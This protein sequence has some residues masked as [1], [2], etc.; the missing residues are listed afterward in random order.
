MSGENV[1]VEPREILT[2]PGRAPDAVVRYGPHPEHLVDV[3]LPAAGRDSGPAPVVVLLHGGFWRQE[4]DRTHLRPMAEALAQSGYI[5]AT[6][7][8]RRSGGDGGWPATFRDVHAALGSMTR[9]LDEAAPGRADPDP[10][11]VVGHS[12]GGHLAIWTCLQPDAPRVRAVVALAPVADL[13]EAHRRGLGDG[14]VAALMGGGPDDHPEEYAAA[15]A[16]HLLTTRADDDM[17]VVVV[18]GTEDDRVP[19]DMSRSLTNVDLRELP[20]VEHFGLIDPRSRAWADV[21]D[22]IGAP[23]R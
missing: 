5:V 14:A 22:A 10:V 21:L 19:V 15:D 8:F 1:D 16:A 11:T 13:Y 23:R 3:H 2:R 20:G 17:P 4:F 7:E 12:A 18:H 6:P 9:C